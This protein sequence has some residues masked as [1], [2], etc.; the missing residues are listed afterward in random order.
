M[1]SGLDF[2]LMM[3]KVNLWNK[4]P[5]G[6]NARFFGIL[7][8]KKANHHQYQNDFI[9]LQ[10]LVIDEKI[11]PVIHTIF[12]LDEIDKAHHELENGKATGYILIK[13]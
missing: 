2:G 9:E 4:L 7:D 8:S 1:K 5:N 3:L 10:Q 11:T 13:N 6:K 12:P